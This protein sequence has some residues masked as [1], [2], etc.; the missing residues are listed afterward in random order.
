VLDEWIKQGL[1]HHQ[2]GRLEDAKHYYNQALIINPRHPEALHL[3]GL[4]ALQSGDPAQAADLISKAVALQ[5]R[6]WA[7]QGNLAMALFEAGAPAEAL[8]AFRKAVKLNPDEPQLQM[9]VANCL[10]RQGELSQAEAQLRKVV[11]RAPGFALAWFNLANAVRDQG[12]NEEAVT[13][14]RHALQADG[15]LVDAHNNLGNLLQSAGQLEEA[16]RAYRKALELRP[17]YVLGYCNLASVLI[18]RGRFGEAEASCRQALTHDPRSASAHSIMGSAIAHQGRLNEALQSLRQ[19]VA[20]DPNDARL[21]AG[22]GSALFGIGETEEAV[23]L[24]QRARALQ[25]EPGYVEH[26]LATAQLALGEFQQGWIGYRYRHARQRFEQRHPG[27]VL[28]SALPAMLAGQHVCLRREQG[29]GDELFFLRFAGALKA[30]GARLTYCANPK[31]AGLLARVPV[32]DL[33]VPDTG[34]M[35]EA[36]HTLLIGDLP[37]ALGAVEVSPFRA[38]MVSRRPR[39]SALGEWIKALPR[40]LKVNYPELPPPLPLTPLAD[41][42]TMLSNRL[43]ALGPPPYVGLT[44]RGGIAPEEQRGAIWVLFKKISLEQFGAAMRGL[45]GTFL[46]LQ[47]NPEPGEIERLSAQIGKPVH[48]LTALNEDLEAMLALLALIDEYIGVSNTNMHLR[49]G[50]GKTA[51]VLVPCPP[52]WRWM[53]RGEGSPWFPGFCVYRQKADGDWRAAL[54]K[55]S[56]DLL[57]PARGS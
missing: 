40:A 10:A 25:S 7:F 18:D 1:H 36:D 28:A 9:G 37:L 47:R 57:S 45:D 49:A 2:A 43:A 21:L 13:L 44:W 16:E 6:N 12:R 46:A 31:L 4:T 55:L 35:P 38:R 29:L 53:A 20:L 19:A 32:L 24:L 42:L 52:E 3:L 50:V 48:D 5:P 30:R 8:A 11:R 26:V 22:L 23:G 56:N 33:V 39:T 51:R 14:Y 15:Q 34:S 41:Q 27:I 17:D 54:E